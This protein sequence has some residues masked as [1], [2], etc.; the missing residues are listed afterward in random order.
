[1]I[2]V[3]KPPR[4]SAG[5]NLQPQLGKEKVNHLRIATWNVLSLYGSGA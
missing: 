4:N 2:L 1:M 3:E 5:F